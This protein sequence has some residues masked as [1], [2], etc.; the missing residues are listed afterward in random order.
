V[1]ESGEVIH[2]SM[3]HENVADAEQLPRRKRCDIAD[4][5]ENRAPLEFQVDPQPRIAPYTV[6]QMCVETGF[7]CPAMPRKNRAAERADRPAHAS[8]NHPFCTHS[9][10]RPAIHSYISGAYRR[11]GS[12]IPRTCDR[13]ID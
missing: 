7:H 9:S 2:V 13:L 5:E 3:A 10:T 1:I 11:T 4:V 6:H 8:R 12:L